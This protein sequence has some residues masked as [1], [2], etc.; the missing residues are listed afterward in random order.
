[1]AIPVLNKNKVPVKKIFTTHAT[2]LGRYLASGDTNFYEHLD[3][4]DS[5]AA[6]ASMA[7]Y[8]RFAIERAAAWGADSFTTVSDITGREAEFLLGKKP[9]HLLPNGLNIN[10]FTALHEFQ[11]LHQKYKQM[12]NDFIMGHFFPYY[13]FDLD[14]TLY[15]FTSGRYEYKNKG[16]DLFIES[17]ARLNWRLKQEKSP[18]T[19]VVFIITKA[20]IKGINVEILK[21]QALFDELKNICGSIS[22]QI[23]DSLLNHT[24]RGAMPTAEE[25]ID[26]Y[27]RLRIRRIQNAWKKQGWPSIC[28][29]DMIFDG[30][31]P[32]LNQLRASHLLNSPEDPVKV[33]FHPEFL[34]ATGPLLGLDY[35]Q[36]VRGCHLG[37]FP[38]YYEPWGYTP[39]ECAAFG[40]PSVTSDLSGFGSY[41]QKQ[42]ALPEQYGLYV[43][44]RKHKSFN[45]SADH[46]SKIM[47]EIANMNRRERIDLRNRVESESVM[48]DWNEMFLNYLKSY[49]DIP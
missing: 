49:Q 31:D 10:R 13:S 19:I 18:V 5:H 48:F 1:V 46:L 22:E 12:I 26:E 11:N 15:F 45:E 43:V 47:F 24:V 3:Q 44:K 6:A 8:P 28:T 16:Y 2:L 32:V 21:S 30:E 35:D 42:L 38:S 36:F 17:L 40:V 9:D 25:L 23:E 27:G 39:M 20:A 29:H 41:I 34:N 14:N 4:I 33:I 7:I 37:V